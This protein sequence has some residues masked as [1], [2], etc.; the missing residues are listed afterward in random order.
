[1]LVLAALALITG[2]ERILALGTRARCYFEGRYTVEEYTMG[3]PWQCEAM[4][5]D[6]SA[7]DRFYFASEPCRRPMLVVVARRCG[8]PRR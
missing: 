7:R 8:Y 1:M 6:M 5:P 3:M 2:C 4:T